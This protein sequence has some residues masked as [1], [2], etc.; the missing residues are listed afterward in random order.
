MTVKCQGNLCYDEETG[1]TFFIP[2]KKCSPEAYAKVKQQAVDEGI[3]FT[4][5]VKEE[6]PKNVKK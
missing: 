1:K 5:L 2:D 4:K 3:A 6:K